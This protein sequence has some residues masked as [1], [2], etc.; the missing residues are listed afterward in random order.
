[1]K[2]GRKL[3]YC[4]EIVERI[5]DHVK[6]GMKYIDAAHMENISEA[7]FYIWKSK[8]IEFFK[9]LKDAE[10]DFK[11]FHIRNIQK[12]SKN[13]WQASAFLLQRKFPEEFADTI[14][15][16]VSGYLESSKNEAQK[17]ERNEIVRN[18]LKEIEDARKE[19][20]NKNKE[21]LPIIKETNP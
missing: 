18:F 20:L 15:Q 3:K 17:K 8:Y 9:L 13:V 19:A 4:P 14:K 10:L 5:C 2:V 7:T 16:Q 1:M 11:E 6:N 21:T 12:H